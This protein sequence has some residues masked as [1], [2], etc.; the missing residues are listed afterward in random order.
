MSDVLN[1]AEI[2][3]TLAAV[4]SAK[5]REARAERE[6]AR[7]MRFDMEGLDAEGSAPPPYADAREQP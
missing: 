7:Q 4:V 5:E 2:E 1:D 6:R 3:E